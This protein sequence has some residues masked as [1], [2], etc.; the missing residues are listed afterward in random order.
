MLTGSI[1]RDYVLTFLVMLG[2][3][4]ATLLTYRFAQSQF[5]TQGFSELSFVKRIMAFL[6][7][8]MTMGMGV[9]VPREVARVSGT[10]RDEIKHEILRN[11]LLVTIVLLA[12]FFLV[13]TAFSGFLT[14]L[15]FGD[16]KFLYLLYPMAICLQGT[17][18]NNLAYSYFRGI[19]SF[20]IANCLQAVN[21]MMSPIVIILL[22][23]NNIATYLTIYGSALSFVSLAFIAKH[24][25]T[26]SRN[27]LNLH[28]LFDVTQY[29]MKRLPGDIALQL[30]FV[31][32]PIL[33]AHILDFKTVGDVS[34]S[35]TILTLVTVPISPV[36]TLLLP[37][38][39]IWLNQGRTDILRRITGSVFLKLAIG[40]AILSIVLF[41]SA[42]KAIHLFLPER[43]DFDFFVLKAMTL[44]VLPYSAYL[45]LRSFID[46]LHD[47]AYNSLNCVISLLVFL[48]SVGITGLLRS[49]REGIIVGL[50]LGFY[51]LGALT[52][53]RMHLDKT[54]LLHN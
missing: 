7:T 24:V 35:L 44:T 16:R 29:S 12:V 9:G 42:E 1:K 28:M 2:V 15:L 3:M 30:M 49:Y 48:A 5:G 20:W 33:T 6:V 46:A 23:S 38:T 18:L 11:S 51:A 36:S 10:E 4:G 47:K 45:Y 14:G 13:L 8:I 34:F 27:I 39:M 25:F 53:H 22:F 41:F 31:I 37:K 17:M 40:G 19:D 21:F 32:P 26:A 54:A 43:A 52:Y 50:I